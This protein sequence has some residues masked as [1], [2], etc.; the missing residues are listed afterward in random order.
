MAELD[1]VP[2]GVVEPAAVL[3]AMNEA[4]GRNRD[5]DWYRWKHLE[6]PWGPSR[7]WVALDAGEVVGTRLFVP[8]RLRSPAGEHAC[9]RAMDG[10]VVPRAR[11][12]GIFSSLVR[13]ETEVLAARPEWHCVYSTSVPSSREAYRALGWTILP[14]VRASYLFVGPRRSDRGLVLDAG[15]DDVVLPRS[16]VHGLS[17][18]W[19]ASALRWRTDPRGGHAYQVALLEHG[20]DQAGLCFRTTRVRGVRLLVPLLSWGSQR[21]RDRLLRQAAGAEHCAVVLEVDRRSALAPLRAGGSTVS[22]WTTDG[23]G[24]PD[25]SPTEA[26]SWSWSGADLEGVL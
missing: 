17:T 21:A 8:W 6:G 25:A 12:R 11:R 3:A 18:A 1:Y 24:G 7:G 13:L 20:P 10:A 26:R 14:R 16:T 4:F 15:L 22:V 19:T 23:Q 9:S 2:L 5:L